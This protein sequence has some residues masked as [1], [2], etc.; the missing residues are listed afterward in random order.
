MHSNYIKTL[1]FNQWVIYIQYNRFEIENDH[2]NQWMQIEN[3]ISDITIV[4]MK[5]QKTTA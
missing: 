2:Y 5:I 3:Q 1:Q 4:N